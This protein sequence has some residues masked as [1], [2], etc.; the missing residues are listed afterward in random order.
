M[1]D[2]RPISRNKQENINTLIRSVYDDK[3]PPFELVNKVTSL[4]PSAL[5]PDTPKNIKKVFG[6]PQTS[7]DVPGSQTMTFL[8]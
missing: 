3:H 4:A 7:P 1:I 6:P 2:C 5:F 8:T